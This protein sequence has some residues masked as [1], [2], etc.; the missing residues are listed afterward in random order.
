MQEISV[1]N[2]MRVFLHNLLW[3][4]NHYG[5]TKQEIAKML[6][7]SEDIWEEVENMKNPTRITPEVFYKIK[8]HFDIN[9]SDM[10]YRKLK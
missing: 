6:E 1:E 9:P 10:I 3:L 8:E 4:K 2:E 5:Y 7:I